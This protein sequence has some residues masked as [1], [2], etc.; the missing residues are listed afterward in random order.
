MRS[1]RL[2]DSRAT[3]FAGYA[4]TPG[5]SSIFR[6]AG[7]PVIVSRMPGLHDLIEPGRTGQVVPAESAA[8]L[9]QTMLTLFAD[10]AAARRMGDQARQT[11]RRYA[12]RAVAERHVQ[13]YEELCR[14]R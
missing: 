7:T 3:G 9:A 4:H 13:L 2:A 11:A 12:W 1:L 10:R 6:A 14:A 5:G 8:D